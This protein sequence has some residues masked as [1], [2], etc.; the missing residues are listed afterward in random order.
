MSLLKSQNMFPSRP[1]V[2][3]GIHPLL[4]LFE[5]LVPR[6]LRAKQVLEQTMGERS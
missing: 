3:T 1:T 6:L 4:A 5:G 2:L